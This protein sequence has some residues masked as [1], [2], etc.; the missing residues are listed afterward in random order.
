MHH[1]NYFLKI[2]KDDLLSMPPLSPPIYA[3]I[4]ITH[5]IW[6][7]DLVIKVEVVVCGGVGH[8]PIYPS[9]VESY[10]VGKP[11]IDPSFAFVPS[12]LM[13]TGWA[14]LMNFVV[15]SIPRHGISLV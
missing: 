8:A 4:R 14:E 13:D 15:D 11:L 7:Q 3:H 5:N 10:E 1:E 12:S 6:R 2:S 9:H